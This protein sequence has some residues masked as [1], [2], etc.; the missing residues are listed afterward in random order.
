MNEGTREYLEKMHGRVWT[1]NELTDEYIVES[2]L[3]P[4]VD[5]IRKADSA[6]GS[7]QFQHSPRFYHSPSFDDH[8]E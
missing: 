6:K 7:M 1:T 5:V 2:F 8:I 4:Y 3:A